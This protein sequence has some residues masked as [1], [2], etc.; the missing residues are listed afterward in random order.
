MRSILGYLDLLAK[1]FTELGKMIAEQFLE[2]GILV[3]IYLISLFLYLKAYLKKNRTYVLIGAV[4]DL[5]AWIASVYFLVQ[6]QG[7]Y[8]QEELI[9]MIALLLFQAICIFC[10]FR[11]SKEPQNSQKFHIA[12]ICL[13]LLDFA[14][15]IILIPIFL[16]QVEESSLS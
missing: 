16:Q 7:Q 4:L 5:L 11:F 1:I 14:F 6:L 15:L 2:M 8:S 10:I 3:F 9:A 12:V 13:V